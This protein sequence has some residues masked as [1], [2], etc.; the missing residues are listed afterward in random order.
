MLVSYPDI[1]WRKFFGRLTPEGQQALERTLADAGLLL[2]EYME[3]VE[4][5]YLEA[6]FLR[7]A[8][9]AAVRLEVEADAQT[10]AGNLVGSYARRKRVFCQVRT[11]CQTA[12]PS[13]TQKL[14]LQGRIHAGIEAM[15]RER[16]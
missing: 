7:Q 5:A 6:F 1:N 3:L 14:L 16:R 9:H 15:K 10:I 13:P 12:S 8:G 11:G 2:G 4:R